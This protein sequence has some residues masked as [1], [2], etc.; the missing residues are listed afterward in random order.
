MKKLLTIISVIAIT[1]V[2]AQT[3]SDSLKK[4]QSQSMYQFGYQ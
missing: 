3:K 2:L 4:L 1:T